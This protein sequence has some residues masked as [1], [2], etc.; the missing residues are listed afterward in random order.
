MKRLEDNEIYLSTT[1]ACALGDSPS[2][3][4]YAITSDEDLAS[5]TIRVSLSHL[6]TDDDIDY[7]LKVFKDCLK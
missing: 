3:S 6:T 2:K 4:V 5:N 1:T 7:F